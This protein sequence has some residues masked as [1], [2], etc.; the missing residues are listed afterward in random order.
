MLDNTIIIYQ[1]IVYDAGYRRARLTAA[2]ILKHDWNDT[3]KITRWPLR[4]DNTQI[5]APVDFRQTFTRE[6]LKGLFINLW[7]DC[8]I[9]LQIAKK[10]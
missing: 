10:S 3:E 1:C 7:L 5:R 2:H 8:Q 4:K 9:S 6:L